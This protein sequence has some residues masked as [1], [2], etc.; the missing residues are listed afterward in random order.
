M[1]DR[2]PSIRR[3]HLPMRHPEDLIPHLAGREAHWKPGFSA[4]ALATSWFTAGGL[5]ASVRSVLATRPDFASAELVDAF[6]ERKVD[7]PDGRRPS[8]TDLLA[9][10]GLVDRI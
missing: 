10:L 8:Q 4:H 7:L 5:P 3:L 2:S 9:I 1:V 6:L